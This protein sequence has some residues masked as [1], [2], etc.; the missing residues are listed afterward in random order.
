M[1]VILMYELMIMVYYI[2]G[3]FVLFVCNCNYN[4]W[5]GYEYRIIN[6][7]IRIYFY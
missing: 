3:F 6:I 5:I 7:S 2:D 4:I 1:V